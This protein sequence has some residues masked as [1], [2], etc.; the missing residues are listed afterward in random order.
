MYMDVLSHYD[1]R[2][3]FKQTRATG[4]GAIPSTRLIN[5][6]KHFSTHG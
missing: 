6:R 5:I 1:R 3:M 2:R 4:L